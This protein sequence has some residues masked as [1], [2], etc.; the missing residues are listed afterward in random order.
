MQLMSEHSQQLKAKGVGFDKVEAFRQ[1]R[2][3]CQ[4]PKKA[5]TAVALQ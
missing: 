3:Y 2:R 1:G 4:I 5:F